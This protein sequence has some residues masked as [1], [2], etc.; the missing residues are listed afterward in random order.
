MNGFY[1]T[2]AEWARIGYVP[3]MF[4]HAFMT[5]GLLAALMVGPLLGGLG[6]VVVTKKLSFFTQT[7]GNA[8]L[9]GVALGLLI[10]EPMDRTYGGLYAFCLTVAWLMTFLRHRTRFAS[11]TVIGVV[12]AQT[13]GLR[14]RHACAR[15][16]AVQH[17]SNRS[18]LIRELDHHLRPRPSHSRG[19]RFFGYRLGR[20]DF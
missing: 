10:G 7:I 1:Q 14:D 13:L 2:V 8:A 19:D 9:T 6:V 20:V 4:E 17:P 18:R 15:H 12:L 5:R 3:A 16:Q 11:D